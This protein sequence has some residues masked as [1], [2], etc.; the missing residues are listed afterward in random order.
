MCLAIEDPL[1]TKATKNKV[2]KNELILSQIF[3]R[4][5]VYHLFFSKIILT[6]AGEKNK[7]GLK[8]ECIEFDSCSSLN[9][10]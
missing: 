3:S 2:S 6:I 5:L 4:W 10:T 8:A 1:N 7:S 9:T